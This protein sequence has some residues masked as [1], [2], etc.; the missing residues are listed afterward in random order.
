[1]LLLF[2]LKHLNLHKEENDKHI[3]RITSGN[4]T[5]A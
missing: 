5:N 3:Y 1:M 4:F 2:I